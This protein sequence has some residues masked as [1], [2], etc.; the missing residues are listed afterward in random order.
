MSDNLIITMK[1]VRAAK[2]CSS[3]ARAFF[4]KHNLDWKDFLE[5]GI[6][7]KRVAETNDAMALRVIEVARGRI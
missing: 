3:G 6:T 4:Q 7:A 1:D 2:M 5:N